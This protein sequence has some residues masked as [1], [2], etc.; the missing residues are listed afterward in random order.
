MDKFV[1]HLKNHAKTRLFFVIELLSHYITT[2]NMRASFFFRPLLFILNHEKI[3]WWIKNFGK[4]GTQT[5]S[6]KNKI[7]N[8]IMTVKLRASNFKK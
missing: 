4:M 2:I 5:L 1:L 6:C 7:M 3:I 8:G